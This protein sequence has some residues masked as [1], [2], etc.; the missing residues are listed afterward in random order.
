M[1]D[2]A[3]AIASSGHDWRPHFNRAAIYDMRDELDHALR[4]LNAAI[5][6]H[7]SNDPSVFILRGRVHLQKA[8][9][10]PAWADFDKAVELAPDNPQAYLLRGM[11]HS[12]RML[13]TIEDCRKSQSTRS[14]LHHTG[15]PCSRPPNFIPALEDFKTAVAKKPDYAEPHFETGRIMANEGQHESAV[16]AYSAAIRAEPKY[17][18]AYNSRGVAY[19]NLKKR[20]LALADYEE[21]IRTDPRNKF[22]WAN[23]ASLLASMG[24]RQRAIADYRKALDIDQ[25]YAFAL[26]GLRRLGIKP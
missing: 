2:Y 23:R 3:R 6:D 22:A 15:G 8:A 10:D 4:D 7:S 17:S 12:R 14:T 18:M 25:N 9:H 24:Q 21:A 5:A 19:F 13:A 11:A 20:E 26:E 16:R 1:A